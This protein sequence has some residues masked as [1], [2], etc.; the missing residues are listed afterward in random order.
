MRLTSRYFHLADMTGLMI[1]RFLSV[2]SGT[3]TL[4]RDSDIDTEYPADVD[5]ENI[6]EQGL[7]PALPGEL[8]KISI[9]LA[10]FKICRILSHSLDQLLP[11]SPYYHFPI[12]ELNSIA[13]ELDQWVLSI[14][15]HLRMQFVND[16]PST[17]VISDRSPLLVCAHMLLSLSLR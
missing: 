10:L 7:S 1:A 4:L 3:P 5:D 11:V 13:N 12:Q 14:P 9:A 17:G 15:A 2:S 6:A 8:T 16:K